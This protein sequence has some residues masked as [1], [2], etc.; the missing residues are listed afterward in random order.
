MAVKSWTLT[1]VDAGKY[2]E[3]QVITP[4][5]V[6]GKASGYRIHKRRL[7]G[8]LSDGLTGVIAL[9]PSLGGSRMETEDIRLTFL[10]DP[11]TV[12]HIESQADRDHVHLPGQLKHIDFVVQRNSTLGHN[13]VYFTILIHV[14]D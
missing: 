8:G 5:D 4:Q 9:E 6:G 12:F 11:Q 7:R 14:T 2:V 1:D 3:E 10:H 13:P